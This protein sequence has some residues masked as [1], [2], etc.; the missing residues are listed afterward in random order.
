MIPGCRSKQRRAEH[1]ARSSVE[2]GA[3]P[4]LTAG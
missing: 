4:A 2:D 1:E 3:R